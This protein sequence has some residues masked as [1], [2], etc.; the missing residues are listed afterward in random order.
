MMKYVY[1]GHQEFSRKHCKAVNC[2]AVAVV[3]EHSL[4]EKWK[5]RK[6]TIS[7]VECWQ[8]CL[9][10]CSCW[11]MCP[12]KSHAWKRKKF[13]DLQLQWVALWMKAI[14]LQWSSDVLFATKSTLWVSSFRW[15]LGAESLKS[16]DVFAKMCFYSVLMILQ[17]F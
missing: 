3:Q 6:R 9:Q 10:M 8:D 17:H 5:T 13:W 12:S 7:F 14:P 11:K 15:L 16:C 4:G 1:M 2:K